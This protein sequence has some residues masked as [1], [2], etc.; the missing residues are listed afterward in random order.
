MECFTA[1]FF[2]NFL[3]QLSKFAFLVICGLGT[4]HHQSQ[5]F[6]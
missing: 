2:C 1:E 5:A 4:T 6:Q 3:A